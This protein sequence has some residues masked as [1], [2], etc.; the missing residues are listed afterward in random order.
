MAKELAAHAAFD[1]NWRGFD[2]C[3]LPSTITV[4]DSR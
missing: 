3:E 2:I 1:A 4:Y